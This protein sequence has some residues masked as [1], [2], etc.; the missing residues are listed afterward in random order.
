MIFINNVKKVSLVAFF[1][2]PLTGSFADETTEQEHSAVNDSMAEMDHSPMTRLP[3]LKASSRSADQYSNGYTLEDAPYGL[4]GPR[5]LK[6]ADELL[7]WGLKADRIEYVNSGDQDYRWIYDTQFWIGSDYNKLLL[8]AEGEFDK[9]GKLEESSSEVL[10]SYA[11]STFWNTQL[12]VNYTTSDAPSQTWLGAGISG[13]APYWF[14][15]DMMAYVTKGG[16]SAYQLEVEY[17]LLLTQQLILQPRIEL[18]AFSKN[19]DQQGQGKGLSEMIAGL[20]LRYE[21]SRQI[22]PYIGV[23]W[24]STLGNS[25]DMRQQSGENKQQTNWIAGLSF[26]F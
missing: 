5:Q 13:L 3:T 24:Q 23:E 4:A 11:L 20:R 21:I 22:A 15:I 19:D 9:D 2:L 6:L 10:W 14:E 26:W 18:A 8:N 7:F 1:I 25:A 16:Q 12:G 17:E